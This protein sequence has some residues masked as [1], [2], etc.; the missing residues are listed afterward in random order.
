MIFEK[1]TTNFTKNV[2]YMKWNDNNDL[3]PVC[4][5]T[6][7]L[8][9]IQVI[10]QDSNRNEK[11][12]G[13]VAVTNTDRMDNVDNQSSGVVIMSKDEIKCLVVDETEIEEVRNVDTEVVKNKLL[14]VTKRVRHKSKL[15]RKLVESRE[16]LV[17]KAKT[18]VF[19]VTIVSSM[20]I[21]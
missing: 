18:L 15:S 4:I 19:F 1:D 11:Q 13:Q 3:I 12:T 6:K 17:Q 14:V 8:A 2:V 7:R 9:E 20:Y 5:M 21:P 10:K 16:Y